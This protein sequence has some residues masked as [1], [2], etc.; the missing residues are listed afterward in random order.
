MCD[1]ESEY[2]FYLD[3]GFRTVIAIVIVSFCTITDK[4]RYIDELLAHGIISFINSKNKGIFAEA[5]N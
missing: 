1:E 3:K 2:E 5:L 4:R